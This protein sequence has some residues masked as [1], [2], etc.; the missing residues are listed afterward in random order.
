MTNQSSHPNYF[1][2]IY[3]QLFSVRFAYS[4]SYEND[5]FAYCF[6]TLRHN[7]LIEIVVSLPIQKLSIFKILILSSIELSLQQYFILNV[8]DNRRL[9]II[10][11]YVSI[12]I[13]NT[14]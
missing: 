4:V 14:L 7:S 12:I 9:A 13:E 6:C 8:R 10:I 2:N 11:T 5:I 3:T 1:I